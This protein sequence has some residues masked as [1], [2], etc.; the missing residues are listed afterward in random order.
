MFDK[1][2]GSVGFVAETYLGVTSF[3]QYYNLTFYKN[4]AT[5]QYGSPITKSMQAGQAAMIAADRLKAS[6]SITNYAHA[7]QTNF[8]GDP[9]ISL[10]NFSKPDFA[11]EDNQVVM[12]SA[13][14]ITSG[15]FHVKAYLYNIGRAAGDSV[16]VS[17]K[18][19]L[20][21]GSIETILEKEIVSIRNMDS[22]DIDVT[23][24]ANKDAGSNDI[25]VSIDDD[26]KYS[27]LSESNNSVTKSIYIY[28]NGITPVY[29]YNY[30]IIRNSSAAVIAS[31][32]DALA[33]EATY[34]M[35]LDTTQL[36]NSASLVTKTVKSVGG[37]IS[38][39][40]GITYADSVVYYWRV[41]PVPAAGDDYR[42]AKSSFQYIAAKGGSQS[43]GLG[44]SHYGQH[45]MSTF[46]GLE[47]DSMSRKW[48]FSNKNVAML[49]GQAVYGSGISTGYSNFKIVMGTDP[50]SSFY[51]T[52]LNSSLLFNVFD[53]NS[54][55]PYINQSVPAVIENGAIGGFMGSTAAC[56]TGPYSYDTD[57]TGHPNT[58]KSNFQ[59]S[60]QTAADRDKIA[61]FLDWIP[62]G[63]YVV[64]R[65]LVK[66]PFA[67]VP[68]IDAWKSDDG[69][70]ANL[71][72]KLIAQGLTAINDF[73]Q[74]QAGVF[75]FRKDVSSFTPVQEL[76]GDINGQILLNETFQ[77]KDS[78][79]YVTS[80]KFGPAVHWN[81]IQWNGKSDEAT[82]TDHANVEV[83][84][85]GSNGASTVLRTLSYSDQN[86][87][88][89]SI[90]A[91]AYP[92]LQLKL[93]D[94]D[95]INYT[96]FELRYWHIL[97]T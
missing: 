81:S 47:I 53:P 36:F 50:V 92:Y 75:I 8:F 72:T 84:G 59:F 5:T 10:N 57:P 93:R 63:T 27:E 1:D 20:P 67:S 19:K 89:S 33:A 51:C 80:P 52:K 7:E 31:T 78:I 83:I 97:Y 88:I 69:G 94:A 66:A 87:D 37:A 6:D 56:M 24:D 71:Y 15:K 18:H 58:N 70:G 39:D 13:V 54:F 77:G 4:L 41:S 3:L 64:M 76:T 65:L 32:S 2:K 85:I 82:S 79:G 12:P 90:D 86:A 68:L 73:N 35:E 43:D 91:S 60:Y 96:P 22:L 17:V 30:S 25:V 28:A 21:D 45:I 11:V 48:A 46:D 23:I 44:Q 16:K 14:S 29:P 26:N 40:P 9:V 34:V 61:D 95:S 74:P 49:I 55:R 38:F 62:K 42:W